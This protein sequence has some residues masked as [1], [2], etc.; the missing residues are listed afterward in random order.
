MT[1]NYSQRMYMN[2]ITKKNVKLT[3]SW[4][5]E[6]FQYNWIDENLYWTE[7]DTG[8]IRVGSSKNRGEERTLVTSLTSPMSLTLDPHG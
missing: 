1:W 5:S 3:L 7:S 8:V 4:S 6:G 2:V